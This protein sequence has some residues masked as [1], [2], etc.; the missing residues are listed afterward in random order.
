MSST[1][2][3]SHQKQLCQHFGTSQKEQIL[4]QL[5]T[6]KLLVVGDVMLDRYWFCDVHRISPEA[7]VPVALVQRSEYR[8]GGAANV[9][10]NI[11]A[12]GA[13]VNLLSLVGADDAANDLTNTFQPHSLITPHL[14]T[15]SQIKT[16]VKLRIM[17]QHQQLL[18]VDFENKPSEQALKQLTQTH[19]SLISQCDAVIYSDY[20]KGVLTHIPELISQAK[21]AK[22]LILVDPKGSDF[23]RYIGA[24]FMTP[25]RAELRTVMG[26]WHNEA[27][28]TQG[29]NQLM[30]AHQIT[31][32]VL[33]RSEEGMSLF[34]QDPQ[35]SELSSVHFSADAKEVFDVTGAGDTVLATLSTLLACGVNK[36]Q[37]VFWANRA[38]GLKVGKL[39]TSTVGFEELFFEHEQTQ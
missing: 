17:G 24:H 8:A 23:S 4:A 25:N 31:N 3:D 32:V 6:L 27:Q 21:Q 30:Q 36:E 10:T 35:S 19:Q 28:L 26:M 13:Q 11:A 37:A 20:A 9:A 2:F 29:L 12:L 33:T 14:I 1:H 16:T 34:S 18:R 39:G 15:D 5:S 22:K 7:P 38:G